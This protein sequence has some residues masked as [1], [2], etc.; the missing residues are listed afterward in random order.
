MPS[1]KNI[2]S[3]ISLQC[4]TKFMFRVNL[5]GASCSLDKFSCGKWFFFLLYCN[6]PNEIRLLVFFFALLSKFFILCHNQNLDSYLSIASPLCG[7]FGMSW[8]V[9]MDGGW[10][11]GKLGFVSVLR[12]S[13]RVNSLVWLCHHH[14]WWWWWWWWRSKRG[15]PTNEW[16]F[17]QLKPKTWVHYPI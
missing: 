4:I 7:L 16:S 17:L 12:K 3:N 14:V 15:C 6:C 10:K 11:C 9:E 8:M 13:W 2:S 1:Y 5:R